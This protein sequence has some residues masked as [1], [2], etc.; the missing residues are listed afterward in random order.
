[1]KILIASIVT[2][3]VVTPL[4][5]ICTCYYFKDDIMT[6]YDERIA[7]RVLPLSNY[8]VARK[9]E[10]ELIDLKQKV[11]KNMLVLVLMVGS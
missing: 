10:I 3:V 9:K 7:A 8:P 4:V 5:T 2:A 6:F 1:M 11:L